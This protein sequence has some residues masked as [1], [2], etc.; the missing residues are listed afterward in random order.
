MSLTMAR[1]ALLWCAVI[2]YR[3]LVGWLL[4]FLLAHDGM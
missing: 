4:C 1:D 3:V 2:N